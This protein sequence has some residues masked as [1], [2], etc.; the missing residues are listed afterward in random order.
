MLFV[1]MIADVRL[2]YIILYKAEKYCIQY[3]V[4]AYKH[5]KYE[6]FVDPNEFG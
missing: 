6:K 4:N 1:Q 2:P 3:N 5:G